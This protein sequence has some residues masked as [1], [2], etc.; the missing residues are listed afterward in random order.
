MS[1]HAS[2]VT[3]PRYV[4][5]DQ[6][7]EGSAL[8]RV[9]D[10]AYLAANCDYEAAEEE[11]IRLLRASP[12]LLED[13]L[14]YLARYLL[15]HARGR[16]NTSTA[17]VEGTERSEDGKRVSPIAPQPRYMQSVVDIWYETVLPLNLGRLGDATE[18]TCK[19]LVEF[20][21]G[22]MS[23]MRKRMKFWQAVGTKVG[24]K[25][26]RNVFSAV[27]LERLAKEHGL[28]RGEL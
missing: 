14:H 3:R 9:V 5:P 18:E 1:T 15:R 20:F 25:K 26:V 28:K 19:R 23:G 6:E 21:D 24:A 27:A 16:Y 8:W 11:F 13:G 4:S 17:N 12:T 22:Q 2:E 7:S 10:E